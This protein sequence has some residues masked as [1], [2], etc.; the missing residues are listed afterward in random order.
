VSSSESDSEVDQKSETEVCATL[1]SND[2]NLTSKDESPAS[3]PGKSKKAAPVPAS[4]SSSSSASSSPDRDIPMKDAASPSRSPSP[5]AVSVGKVVDPAKGQKAFS[6]I[7]LRKV[8]AELADDLDKGREAQDFKA[9]SIPMLVH[10]LRQG[11]SLFSAEDKKR[12]LAT[13]A[14]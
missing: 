5:A 7:Y 9:S 2:K 14:V 8:A 11:E 3:K 12:V 13:K 4:S 10:A 1:Q 6:D